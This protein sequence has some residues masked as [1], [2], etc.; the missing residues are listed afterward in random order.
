MV[1]VGRSLLHC[2]CWI[3]TLPSLGEIED[4]RQVGEEATPGYGAKTSNLVREKEVK[5]DLLTIFF[6]LQRGNRGGTW[7]LPFSRCMNCRFP[8]MPARKK[9]HCMGA[10]E[11][12]KKTQLQHLV[13][14][15][16][17]VN[18]S[19]AFNDQNTKERRVPRR[20]TAKFEP[21][22]KADECSGNS[23]RADFFRQLAGSSP[24][25]KRGPF[26]PAVGGG[27]YLNS[28]NNITCRCACR[29]AQ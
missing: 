15:Q 19:L 12:S 23:R 18:N 13:A 22:S 11:R 5:L 9:V 27:F 2:C 1:I 29:S 26:V 17:S 28:F 8:S 6:S 24:A 7:V 20:Q 16:S 21:P 10:G 4:R 25:G 14:L 3:A